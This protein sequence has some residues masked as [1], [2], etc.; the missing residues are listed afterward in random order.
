[1]NLLIKDI[2][3]IPDLADIIEQALFVI[4]FINNHNLVK[5]KFDEIRASLR[6]SKGLVLPVETR[7]YTQFCSVK[8]LIVC[9]TAIIVL[10]DDDVLSL[11]ST[12]QRRNVDKFQSII[13]DSSFWDDMRSLKTLLEYPSNI[14]GK[15]TR[16]FAFYK[17]F[18]ANLNRM[19]RIYPSNTGISLN[20]Q[21]GLLNWVM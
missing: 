18:K 17:T 19:N 9:K 6:L 21:I 13:R 2:C 16:C 12:S 14:I 8:Q 7:W 11:L 3:K 15:P 10:N 5:A 4:K 20:S 1:M